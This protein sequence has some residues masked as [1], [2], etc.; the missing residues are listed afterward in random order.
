VYFAD[1][2]NNPLETGK[3]LGEFVDEYP[4]HTITEYHSSGPKQ[5]LLDIVKDGLV[6]YVMKIRG[7][8]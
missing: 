8:G 2:Q 6:E 1:P 4:N 7:I 5:Y 3:F